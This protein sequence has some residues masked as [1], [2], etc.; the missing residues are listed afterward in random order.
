ME[1]ATRHDLRDKEDPARYLDSVEPGWRNGFPLPLDEDNARNLVNDWLRDTSDNIL[2]Q[3]RCGVVPRGFAIKG[4]AGSGGKPACLVIRQSS[5]LE[6]QVV[7]RNIRYRSEVQGQDTVIWL[8]PQTRPLS[9][10]LTL[11]VR[12]SGG[13]SLSPIIFKVAYPDD[14]ARLIDV[15][16]VV[17]TNN[18]FMLADLLGVRALPTS[19]LGGMRFC[20]QLELVSKERR[21]RHAPLLY[22][23]V[24]GKTVLLSFFQLSDRYDADARCGRSAGCFPARACGDGSPVAEFRRAPLQRRRTS[25]KRATHPRS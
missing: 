12:G 1:L 3:R 20:L 13:S 4:Y 7:D 5:Q 19:R 9:T 16:G 22:I 14:A 15:D 2:L 25:A 8:E 24:R 17:V 10:F 23:G 11:E 6:V 18:G 21:A